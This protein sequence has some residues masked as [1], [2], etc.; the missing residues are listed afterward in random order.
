MTDCTEFNSHIAVPWVGVP[1]WLRPMVLHNHPAKSTC[2]ASER[3]MKGCT[4]GNGCVI[5]KWTEQT[6]EH[7]HSPS[8]ASGPLSRLGSWSSC[9]GSRQITM[10]CA[11]LP[12]DGGISLSSPTYH[13][14]T[15]SWNSALNIAGSFGGGCKFKDKL[16]FRFPKGVYRFVKCNEIV[17]TYFIY[18]VIQ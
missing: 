9:K 13:L 16:Q 18:D 4:W 15:K 5:L 1:G 6:A 14:S 11:L 2:S 17:E 12:L 8:A 10:C 7:A 3:L